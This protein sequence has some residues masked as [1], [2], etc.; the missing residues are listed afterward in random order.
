MSH[1]TV[2]I[3]AKD[4]EELN[5]RLDPFYEQYHPGDGESFDEAFRKGWVEFNDCHDEYLD[6]YNGDEVMNVVK[7]SDGAIYDKYVDRFKNPA[8]F[9]ISPE[10]KRYIHP[11]DAEFTEVAPCEFYDT[12]EEYIKEYH[13]FKPGEKIGYWRNPQ[14][15]WDWWQV[16]GRWMG[17][18][19]LK[20]ENGRPDTADYGSPGVFGNRETD[21]GRADTSL[22]EDIDWVEMK[23]EDRTYRS[24]RWK[25]LHKGLDRANVYSTVRDTI[26]EQIRLRKIKS[27]KFAGTISSVTEEMIVQW[28]RNSEQ[29]HDIWPTLLDYTRHQLAEEIAL[30]EEE[31][32]FFMTSYDQI[33]ELL[34]PYDEYMEKYTAPAGTFGFIDLEGRWHERGNMGWWGIVTE[35]DD[36]YDV[37]WW[38]FVES[39]DGDQRVY[40]VD[41]HI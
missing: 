10:H 8:P 31:I 26:A 27:P 23:D 24:D 6:D 15:K 16:G 39:L 9:D 30:A 34:L 28:N 17:T 3:P 19:I 11:D 13:G 25:A 20:L 14:A 35:R 7:L 29:S 32:E 36:D 38:K 1:F 37:A 2:L 21:I 5:K 4:E 12:F 33:R 22:A 18:L 40:V 41:C